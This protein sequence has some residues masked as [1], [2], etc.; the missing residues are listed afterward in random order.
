[1]GCVE[2][3]VREKSRSWFV[4]WDNP[5]ETYPDLEPQEMSEKVLEMWIDGHTT[6]SGAVAYCISAKGLIHFHM[7]LEDSNMARFSAIKKLYPPAHVQVT[8]GSK[9]RA[10]DYINKRGKF[11]EKGEKVVYVAKYG[12]IKGAQGQRKDLEVIQD[13]LDQGL[14]PQEIMEKNLSY[15]RYD[16]MI[17][18]AYFALRTKETP[19]YREIKVIWHVGDSGTGKTYAVLGLME[20]NPD[21]VYMVTDYDNGGLD[22][23]EGERILFLDEFRGQLRYSVLL[24]MLQGYRQQFHAR[25]SNKIG[26]WEEVHISSVF[27]PE[28]VY[29]EMVTDNRDVDTAKQLFRR[30]NEVCYHYRDSGGYHVY[31]VPMSEYSSYAELKEIVRTGAKDGF[32]PLEKDF[33]EVI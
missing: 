23:Y 25:Y 3:D 7:V 16:K 14:K 13:Y 4:T 6:R 15:R 32:T 21:N 31:T 19:L 30:I 22:M 17:R 9:E 1:M 18:D 11:A 8:R 20:D 2:M 33:E 12:E 28:R 5:Q 10:E 24:S 27:P 26:L 29:R